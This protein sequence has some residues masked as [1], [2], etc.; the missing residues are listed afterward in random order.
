MKS[1]K[2]FK[3]FFDERCVSARGSERVIRVRKEY[4]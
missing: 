4:E 2:G 3:R 1:Y